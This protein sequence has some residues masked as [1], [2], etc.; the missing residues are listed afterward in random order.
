MKKL[1]YGFIC[2]VILGLLCCVAWMLFTGISSNQNKYKSVEWNEGINFT[3]GDCDVSNYSA[4]CPHN[5]QY[6]KTRKKFVFLQCHRWGHTGDF[7]S[8]SLCYLDPENPLEYEPLNCPVYNGV[9]ALLV[10]DDGTWYIWTDTQRYTSVDG[11]TSWMAEML[12][13]PL[14]SRYGVY[15][16]DGTLY[17]GD[18]SGDAGVYRTSTDYGLTWETQDFG[19]DYVDCEASFCKFKGNIYAFLRT[20]T[21]EYGCILKT[22][23]DGSWKVVNDNTLLAGNSNCSPVAFD[24]YIAIAHINRFDCHLYY[25]VWDG[26]DSFDTVDLGQ[27]EKNTNYQGDFHCPTLA[28]GDGYACIAFMMHTY[29]NPVVGSYIYAQ[30]NWVIG[31]YDENKKFLKC[32]IWEVNGEPLEDANAG[33]KTYGLT[34]KYPSNADIHQNEIVSRWMRNDNNFGVTLYSPDSRMDNYSKNGL[35]IPVQNGKLVAFGTKTVGADPAAISPIYILQY[36]SYC[37]VEWNGNRYMC[38]DSSSSS[39]DEQ[40]QLSLQRKNTVYES[41]VVTD[42]YITNTIKNVCYISPHSDKEMTVLLQHAEISYDK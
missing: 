3:A 23:E 42:C 11:G 29:G 8:I 21:T 1:R 6:D 16:I 34:E 33:M 2:V 20:N 22:L 35:L 28:F 39:N 13:T 19:V 7:V 36:Q 24:D 10:T 14:S 4:W 27:V 15:D 5:L 31:R 41:S 17:M 30:N 40:M 25:T 32:N 38:I 37:C 18:D 12:V 9:A 26:T